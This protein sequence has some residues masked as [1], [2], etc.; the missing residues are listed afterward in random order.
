LR[1]QFAVDVEIG[2]EAGVAREVLVRFPEQAGRRG[3]QQGLQ[4]RRDG[5]ILVVLDQ[6]QGTGICQPRF[7]YFAV[8]PV[9]ITRLPVGMEIFMR[10]ISRVASFHVFQGA[11]RSGVVCEVMGAVVAQVAKIGQ[12]LADLVQTVARQISSVLEHHLSHGQDR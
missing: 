10:K 1:R 2:A 12:T 9:E 8:E 6:G 4:F 5:E 7:P 3:L 11:H